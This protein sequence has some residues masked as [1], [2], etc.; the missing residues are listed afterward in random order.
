M[1]L[2]LSS[3]VFGIAVCGIL[4]VAAKAQSQS[5]YVPLYNA[6]GTPYYSATQSGGVPVYNNNPNAPILPM[7]QMVAGKN[8]PSYNYNQTSQAYTFGTTTGANGTSQAALTPQQQA[9][10]EAQYQAQL[11]AQ[12]AYLNSI[13][14][15]QA[16]NGNGLL[17]GGPF[18]T[19]P[20]GD[21]DASGQ[22]PKQRRVIYRE[23]N[24]P[25]AAPPRLFNPDQ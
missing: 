14:Q 25:L 16:G 12:Q 19:T 11:Q 23:V 7:E 20:V 24:S 13:A 2:T 6:T 10:M 3:M 8:A 9:E 1:R 18:G 21:E 5:T 22:A 17:T 4:P 15:Q